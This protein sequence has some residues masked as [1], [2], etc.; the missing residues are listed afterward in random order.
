MPWF[1]KAFVLAALLISACLVTGCGGRFYLHDD[2]GDVGVCVGI[3]QE[4]VDHG[5]ETSENE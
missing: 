1:V 4:G 2:N 3:T 5:E